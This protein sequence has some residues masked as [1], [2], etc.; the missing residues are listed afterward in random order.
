MQNDITKSFYDEIINEI[1]NYSY[2]LFQKIIGFM[3][4]EKM[5]MVQLTLKIYQ[6]P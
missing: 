6:N 2:L 1:Y 5:K 4:M 3:L